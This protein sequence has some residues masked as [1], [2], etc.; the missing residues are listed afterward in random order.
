MNPYEHVS[1]YEQGFIDGVTLFARW[2]GGEQ[3]VGVMGH[4]LDDYLSQWLKERRR[5]VASETRKK[6]DDLN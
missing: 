3:R 2:D 1:D 5:A 6:L 4:R